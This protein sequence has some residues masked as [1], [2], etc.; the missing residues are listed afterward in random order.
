VVF[1]CWIFTGTIL[2]EVVVTSL[3]A[4]SA[5]SSLQRDFFSPALLATLVGTWGRVLGDSVIVLA[6]V[7]HSSRGLD[8]VNGI[9]LQVLALFAL[10]LWVLVRFYEKL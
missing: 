8:F 3:L 5:P 2:L 6:G 4:K 10:G 7:L 9:F 1:V